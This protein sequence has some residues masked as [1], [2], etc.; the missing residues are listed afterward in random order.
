MDVHDDEENELEELQR[1]FRILTHIEPRNDP[2]QSI[3]SH[4][5]QETEHGQNLVLGPSEQLEEVVEGYG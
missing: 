5:F 1:V 3:H 4:D 2:S